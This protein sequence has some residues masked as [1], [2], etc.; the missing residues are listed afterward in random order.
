[1][2]GCVVCLGV[3][4]CGILFSVGRCVLMI[5]VIGETEMALIRNIHETE[6]NE[7]QMDGVSGASMAIMVGRG[8][9]ALFL[10]E[11]GITNLGQRV[12]VGV[13]RALEHGRLSTRCDGRRRAMLPSPSKGE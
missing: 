6:M 8:D 7:V 4:S 5:G 2:L 1:M 11:P 12:S 3:W 9:D 10:V 13:L